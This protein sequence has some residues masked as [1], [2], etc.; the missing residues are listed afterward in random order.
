MKYFFAICVAIFAL[1][2]ASCDKGDKEHQGVDK[3]EYINKYEPDDGKCFVFIGQDLG[4][5]GGLPDYQDG[6]CDSF[7]MPAGVTGYFGIGTVNSPVSGMDIQGNWGSGDCHLDKYLQTERFNNAMIAI[8]FYISGMEQK[9]INGACDA[10]LSRISNWMKKMASRPTFLR[11]GYEFNLPSNKYQPDTYTAAFRYIR[12]FFEKAGVDNVAYVWQS[13]GA[14]LST[15]DYIKWYPGNEYVDWCAYSHF[16]INNGA[17]TTMIDFARSK[18]KPVFI[19]E[20][21]P[22]LD[23]S[24]E[25]MT[26]PEQAEKMWFEWFISFFKVIEDNP[27]VVKA[28]SYINVDWYT[29]PM[30]TSGTFSKIDSRIQKSEYVSNRWKQKVSDSRYLHAKDIDWKTLK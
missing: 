2:S 25:F 11:I 28:F 23:G 8:G 10:S 5:I 24:D 30:W 22:W 6:Y 1:N 19:A 12:D 13:D 27:D 20:A 14:E 29:Q 7:E 15:A 17:S 9:I 16:E 18:G 26:N 4:A 3:Q 21:T